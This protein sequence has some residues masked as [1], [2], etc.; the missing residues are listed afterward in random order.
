M[1]VNERDPRRGAAL[2]VVLAT[3][4]VT[5]G[6][7]ALVA[8]LASTARVAR[9]Q[10]NATWRGDELR[11]AA[12]LAIES[13]LFE[14]SDGVVL[15]SAIQRPVVP[16]LFDQ[17]KIRDQVWTLRIT[18]WDQCGMLPLEL[19]RPGSP[20][21]SALPEGVRAALDREQLPSQARA[22]LDLFASEEQLVF[23]EAPSH[24]ITRF[25]S[26]EREGGRTVPSTR[27][28]SSGLRLGDLVAT[29]NS[30]GHINVRTAP[31]EVLETVFR[32]L[33]IGGLEPVL[34][35]RDNEE[36]PQFSAPASGGSS[37]LGLTQKSDAWSFRIDV[38]IDGLRR[39][40]WVTYQR[41]GA[42]WKRVQQL[43]IPE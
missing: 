2:L 30:S 8:R 31:A 14:Q 27:R 18:A 29:H 10:I 22:G 12:A 23:P 37:R 24:P 17:L 35:A 16:V 34:A 6:S 40:W 26:L 42:Q 20:I 13:W 7:V 4:T 3:M 21:R 25:G 28:D 11:Q 32:G 15:D 39:S 1:R 33:G 5:L 41:Q 38:A 43:V 36:S 9:Q 19:L